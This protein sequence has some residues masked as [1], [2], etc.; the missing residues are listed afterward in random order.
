MGDHCEQ[1]EVIAAPLGHT[2]LLGR[3]I[4][5]FWDVM[6]KY[7]ESIAGVNTRARARRDKEK[8]KQN[9]EALDALGANQLAMKDLPDVQDLTDIDQ[10]PKLAEEGDGEPNLTH[11]TPAFDDSLFR[12]EKLLHKKRDPRQEKRMEQ[13]VNISLSVVNKT[14]LVKEQQ[15][16]PSLA[17][18]REEA[19]ELE[20]DKTI[21][22]QGQHSLPHQQLT[23]GEDMTQI[24]G[25]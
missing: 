7:I 19:K 18:A 25:M 3:D 16:D 10:Q 8:R 17:V 15:A 20:V 12:E 24:M 21:L 23:C 1:L 5:F 13:E 2:A 22:D 14:E 6:K 4:P 11:V 9:E